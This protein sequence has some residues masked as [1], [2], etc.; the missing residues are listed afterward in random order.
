MKRTFTLF[1][2]LLL[3]CIPT[4]CKTKN[5]TPDVT[6]DFSQ[7][8]AVTAGDFSYQCRI[9]RKDGAITVG[10]AST[11]AKGLTMTCNGQVVQYDY[12]DMHYEAQAADLEPANPA[13]AIYQVFHYLQ[14]AEAL[15]A[16]KTDTGYKYEG[17]VP[18]G[19]FILY[20]SDDGSYDSLHFLN[21]DILIEFE[22]D[23]K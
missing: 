18:I 11:A 5:Y 7:N 9:S 20:Q 21:T 12:A 14:T 1:L 8:A 15:N 6:S 13:I 16:K 10:V 19:K 23:T 17:T 3:V 2:L 22:K 4:G